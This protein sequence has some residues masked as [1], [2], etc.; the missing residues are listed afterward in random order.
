MFRN[1]I[2][3]H[4]QI[5]VLKAGKIIPKV[6]GV[7]GGQTKTEYPEKCPSCGGKT[8]VHHTSAKNVEDEM[9]E[10]YCENK[11]CPAQNVHSLCH[12][13][14]TLGV[15]GLGESRVALLSQ[16]GVN[17]FVDFY[18]LKITDFEKCG[19]SERQSLLAYAAIHMVPTPEKYDDDVLKA[20]CSKASLQK[21]V[22]P[23]WKLF[24]AFGIETAGKSA[25]K[26]LVDH[27]GSFE[28]IRQASVEE[29]SKVEN[30]GEK[31]AQIIYD[32]LHKNS[33]QIDELLQYIEPELP[34]IGPLTGKTFVFT[35]GFP[36]GK[37]YWEKQVE[38]LGGKC[39]GSVSKNTSFVVEG[40]DA[41]EK[42]TKAIKL[43]ITVISLND[44]RNMLK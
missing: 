5:A 11:T 22:I 41:G 35:G 37:S 39:S 9:Y 43:N 38:N 40:T 34:K 21:Q 1:K 42:K 24:A 13:L 18:K 16:G 26:A 4:T 27:F 2:G 36:E 44:L 7:V 33:D 17:K 15:L 20:K 8:V 28:K 19:L 32:Y 31:T 14:E 30:V 25:G 10:L 12:F 23:L 29:L 6:I 3:I